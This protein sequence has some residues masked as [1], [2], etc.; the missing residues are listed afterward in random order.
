MFWRGVLL[1]IRTFVTSNIYVIIWDNNIKK[2]FSDKIRSGVF[3]ES[4]MAEYEK[5]NVKK[6]FPSAC[7]KDIGMEYIRKLTEI[8][9]DNTIAFGDSNNDRTMIEYAAL[10]IAVENS[11][12]ELKEAADLIV[13]S[14]EEDGPAKY[15]EQRFLSD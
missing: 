11:M 12:E 10:G 15:I 1:Y 14:N 6:V 9:P 8:H 13:A 3:G 4:I 5:I 7:N 2:V